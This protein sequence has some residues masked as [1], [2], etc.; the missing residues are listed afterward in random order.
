[1]K[2]RINNNNNNNTF[3]HE[4]KIHDV[5]ELQTDSPYV[6]NVHTSRSIRAFTRLRICIFIY[7]YIRVSDFYCSSTIA[8]YTYSS[9]SDTSSS[10]S[11]VVVVVVVAQN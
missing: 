9:S 11:S 1:M 5:L 6:Y 3:T 4:L 7:E 10:S 8:G 2:L